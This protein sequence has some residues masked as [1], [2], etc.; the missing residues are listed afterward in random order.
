MHEKQGDIVH[1]EIFFKNERERERE[2]GRE[3][4]RERK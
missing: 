4:E 1:H 2:N 3:R